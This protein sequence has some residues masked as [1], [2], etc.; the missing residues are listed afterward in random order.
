MDKDLEY[1]HIFIVDDDEGLV[2][3]LT[4]CLKRN[5][6]I[7]DSTSSGYDAISWLKSNKADLLL[8]DLHLPDIPRDD[9][10]KELREVHKSPFIVITGHGDERI[11]VE[12]M[13]HGA[14]DYLVKDGNFLEYVPTVVERALKQIQQGR[15]LKIAG[16]ELK[17][18]QAFTT[19]I[20][21]TCDAIVIVL[22][23][24]RRIVRSNRSFEHLT[25]YAF[26][27]IKGKRYEDIFPPV[28]EIEE[29]KR[30]FVKLIEN[31]VNHQN[32]HHL[33]IKKGTPRF[34]AWSNTILRDEQGKTDFIIS[35][36]IDITERKRLETEILEISER[37]QRRIGQD[38]HDGLG[39]QLTGIELLSRVLEQQLA[40][41]NKSAAEQA[42]K[43]ASHV[44]DAIAETRFLARGLFP[45][46]LDSSGLMSALQELVENTKK[47]SHIKCSLECTHPVSIED[48]S[49]ATHLYRIAQEALNNA[50]KH[51]KALHI[52]IILKQDDQKL[53]LIVENDGSPFPKDKDLKEGMGLRIMNFRASSIGASLEIQKGLDNKTRVVCTLKQNS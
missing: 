9:L 16:E 50:V 33:L 21:D 12:I 19:A 24:D 14:M 8:L 34:I 51:A 29:I 49:V 31:G 30:S 48:Y 26:E 35:T 53:L 2:R 45:V 38:L 6:Y 18:R 1:P 47:I 32:E 23:R 11:A 41:K 3:L 37:E 17:K 10:L 39:Q 13:K 46:E 44:R 22:D 4:K 20:L 28:E 42:S 40:K 52:V 36:G 25:G 5:R 43:I 15:A 7:V 27:E